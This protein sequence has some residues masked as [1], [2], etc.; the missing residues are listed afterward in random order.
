MPEEPT[1]EQESAGPPRDVAVHRRAAG[2]DVTFAPRPQAVLSVVLTVVAVVVVLYLIYLLRKPIG[3]IVVAAFLAVALSGP[4]NFLS[5]WVSR[6]KAMALSYLGLFLVP[7]ALLAIVVPPLASNGATFVRKLPSYA[8]DLQDSVH[9]NDRL[10]AIDQKYHLT[11]K[12]EQKANKLPD[13]AGDAAKFLGDLGI[14][15]VNS[16]FALVTIVILSIFILAGGRDWLDTT[17]RRWPEDRADRLRH[18]FDDM[19]GAVV[20]YCAGA[21]FQAFLAGTSTFVV[22]LILG[23][24]FAAP[25][26]VITGLF[27]LLP[28]VGATI[29]AVLV[30]II[31]AFSGFPVI[32]IIWTAWAI[33]YQQVENNVIQPRIQS[34]A[35]GV[36]PFVVVVSVLFGG[37]LLGVIGA[38]LAVPVAATVQVLL[39]D[40]ARW[41]H[42]EAAGAE[43]GAQPEPA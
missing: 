33:L 32:T 10:R 29:A 23:V 25:L 18:T 35:V 28:M 24:P 8:R 13:R 34:R 26:A 2:F 11:Q 4:V 39:R 9:K 16:L 17:L 27:D 6:G 19:G 21:L 42:D 30:G 43:A 36:H 12:L 1:P 31:T 40:W 5:R 22:L 15:L 14:G 37:S 41:R 3:W 20:G 38:I 7:I